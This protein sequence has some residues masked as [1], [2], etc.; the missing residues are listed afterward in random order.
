M[1]PSFAVIHVALA[2]ALAGGCSAKAAPAASDE[3]VDVAC[4]LDALTPQDR[5]RQEVLMKEHFAQLREAR[6]DG[7]GFRFRYHAT[8][9]LA[10]HLAELVGLEHR[11]CPFLRFELSWPKSDADAGPELRIIG[12]AKVKPLIVA[13]FTQKAR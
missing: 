3:E 13:A 5:E 12:D 2:L 10:V 6:E 7:D 11:C 1:K 8:P 4:R 9:T